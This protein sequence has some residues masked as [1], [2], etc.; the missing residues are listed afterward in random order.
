MAD[1][2]EATEDRGPARVRRRTRRRTPV[3]PEG[4]LARLTRQELAVLLLVTEGL[5]AAAIA[6]QHGVVARTV[7]SQCRSLLRKMGCRN[8]VQLTRLAVALGMVPV[9]WRPA[10]Q[11][12]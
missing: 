3:A 7:E 2:G 10:A 4:E 11:Q 6:V 9:E 5:S 1:D 12:A 8:R